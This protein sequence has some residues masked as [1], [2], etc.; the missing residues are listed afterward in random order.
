MNRRRCL[1]VGVLCLCGLGAAEK[2]KPAAPPRWLSDWE[3]ARKKARTSGKP[4]FVVF[5]CE[6]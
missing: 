6:H 2:E 3:A 1:F 5:R 4:L